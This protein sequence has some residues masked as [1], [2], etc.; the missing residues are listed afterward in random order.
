MVFNLPKYCLQRLY[1][2]SFVF[3]CD[4]AEY[5]RMLC[6]DAPTFHYI[7]DSIKHLITKQKAHLRRQIE[8]DEELSLT[9]YYLVTGEPN[10]TCTNNVNNIPLRILNENIGINKQ[11]RV[12]RVHVLV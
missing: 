11:F 7:L 1:N 3:Q 6:V 5:Q 12:L 2:T 8:A 10:T 9:L 4:V